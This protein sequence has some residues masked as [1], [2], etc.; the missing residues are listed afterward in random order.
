[1]RAEP[2]A[3]QRILIQQR[4]EELP[5]AG[6]RSDEPEL[7]SRA[8]TVFVVDPDVSTLNA[9][10][11]LVAMMGLRCETYT[12]GQ[13]FTDAYSDSVAGC[14][15][16]EIKIPE[17]GGVQIQRLLKTRKHDIPVIFLTAHPDVSIAVEAIRAGAVHFLQKPP[18]SNELWNAI[19]EALEEDR[20]RRR[21][22]IRRE[23]LKERLACLTARELEI[24]S[25]IGQGRSNQ[26]I[27][28]QMNVGVR[29]VEVRHARLAAK[30]NVS[31]LKALL[32]IAIAVV[33]SGVLEDHPQSPEAPRRTRIRGAIAWN[34]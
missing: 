17:V 4:H 8:A 32:E 16:L 15:I 25:L 26:Q 3:R 12:S 10:R 2:P 30:L 33:T 7:I 18:R 1:V 29:T 13:E 21:E 22:R 24:L 11:D 28:S 27:A 19:E 23:S 9:V 6:P 20:T 14:V 34:D 5:P 31:S